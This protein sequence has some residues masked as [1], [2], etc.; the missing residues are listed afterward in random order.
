MSRRFLLAPLLA[1]FAAVLTAAPAAGAKGQL[2][3]TEAGGVSFPDRAFVLTLPK[4]QHLSASQLQV[5][6]NGDPVGGVSVV[7]AGAAR[8]NEFGVVLVIDASMS[9]EGKPEQAALS[10]ARA[11]ATQRTVQEELGVVTYNISP[12]VVLPFTTDQAEIDEALSKE[13]TFVYGT[14]IYDAVVRSLDLL[15]AAHISAG[16]VVVLSDGQEH[17]GH[18]DTGKHETEE[19][20]AAAARA[21]HVRVFGVGLRSPLSNFQVLKKLADDTGAHYV[22]AKS[23]GALTAIYNQLGSQLAHEYLL[24][25]RSNAGPGTGVWVTVRVK[26]VS[27]AVRSG[28]ATLALPAPEV[29]SY[30][31]A[32]NSFWGSPFT[33]IVFSVLIVALLGATLIVLFM[34]RR[35]TVQRR[36]A[37]FVSLAQTSDGKKIGSAFPERVIVNTEKSLE[38]SRW[39]KRFVEE[40]ELSDIKMKPAHIAIWTLLATVLI[41]W[42]FAIVFT[43]AAIVLGLLVPLIVWAAIR[44][45]VESKRSQF[46]EQLPDNL[47]VLASA[48]RAG[49]SFIGALSVVVEDAPEPTR[50]ELRR[51]VA[52]EQLGLPLEAALDVVVKRMKSDDLGQVA[53]VAVLQRETGGSTAEV[54]DRV[55]ETVRERQ[56]VR[57]LVRTL[58]AAGRFSRWVVTFLPVA[59]IVIISLLAPDY[60]KPLFTHTS[61]RILIVFAALLVIGGSLVIKKI[62]DIKV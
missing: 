53:L 12:T 10:A 17:R 37:E 31:G 41:M 60:L 8:A 34:P 27:G 4:N 30:H 7:P 56:E 33:M 58:T 59:L 9:M 35:R 22:E 11:F 57:R 52:D 50:S 15:K 16:S 32:G 45:K 26:G 3:L 44:R 5:L 2:R 1:L 36:L 38:G 25:Y 29:E 43:T 14:H 21:A 23:L 48:L 61:G 40:V 39:W 42:L 19:T 18:G 6:E 13:P 47:A 24:R 28:Y 51:V 54:L 62:V 46:A 20:A 55:V 49:H